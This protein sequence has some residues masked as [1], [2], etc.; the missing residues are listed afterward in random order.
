MT[1]E[2]VKIG[3]IGLGNMGSAHVRHVI[4]LPNTELTAICDID[5]AM[6]KRI[7]DKV[8]VDAYDNYETM[9]EQADLD[10]IIIATPHYSHPDITLAGFAKGIHVLVEK[11]NA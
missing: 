4:N 5:D 11:P 7:T 9:L 2:K 10:G 3:I 6:I 1:S 8:E